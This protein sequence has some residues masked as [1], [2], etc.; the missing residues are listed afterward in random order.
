MGP[1]FNFLIPSTLG[2]L[3]KEFEH[4]VKVVNASQYVL[5][6]EKD[7]W[8]VMEELLKVVG[9]WDWSKYREEIFEL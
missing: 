8:K 9:A 1:V 2:E 6:S 7:S 3:F 5:D 4:I